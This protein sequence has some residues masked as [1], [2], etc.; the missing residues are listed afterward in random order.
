[1][2][3]NKEILNMREKMVNYIPTILKNFSPRS[4]L[5]KIK[6]IDRKKIYLYMLYTHTHTHTHTHTCMYAVHAQSC[7]TFCSSPGSSVYGIF[8]ARILEVK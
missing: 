5:R 3:Q 6:T 1:M 8:Q 2:R 4:M 7:L